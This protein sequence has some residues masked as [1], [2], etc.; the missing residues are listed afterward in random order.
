MSKDTR[1]ESGLCPPAQLRVPPSHPRAL[2]P[3]LLHCPARGMAGYRQ[4]MLT[5]WDRTP[6][7]IL[8]CPVFS[9]P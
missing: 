2:K 1:A 4:G 5:L 7:L 8:L 3:M 9:S 6:A